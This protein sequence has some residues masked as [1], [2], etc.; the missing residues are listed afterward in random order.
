ME[1]IEKAKSEYAT[2]YAA[3]KVF[4]EENRRIADR[5]DD[6]RHTHEDAYLERLREKRG[7]NNN[8][9]EMLERR[10]HTL[11]L[12]IYGSGADEHTSSGDH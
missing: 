10:A 8:F 5:M 4:T 3:I 9:I 12:I 2:L 6:R 11:S 1:E 7:I